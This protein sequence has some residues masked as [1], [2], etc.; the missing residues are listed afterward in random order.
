MYLSTVKYYI[1]STYLLPDLKMGNT[2]NILS[3]T[4]IILAFI[5]LPNEHYFLNK[6]IF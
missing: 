4:I 5:T 6:S 3:S 1:D 2:T